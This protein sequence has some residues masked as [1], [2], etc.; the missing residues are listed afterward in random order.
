MAVADH[1]GRD[2][3]AI[4][5]LQN[6]GQALGL[7]GAADRTIDFFDGHGSRQFD[8]QIHH[9]AIGYRHPRG[10]AVQAALKFRQYHTHRLGGAGGGG[11]DVLRRGA[12]APPVRMGDIGEALVIGI[13][14]HR[15]DH[16]F[17]NTEGLVQHPRHG[18]QAIGGAARVR[19]NAVRRI[20]TGLVHAQHHRVIDLVLRRHG[21]H[22]PRCAGIEMHLELLALAKHP[23]RLHHG[24]DAQFGPGQPGRIAFTEQSRPAVRRHEVGVF[25]GEIVRKGAHHRVVVEQITQGLVIEEIVDRDDFHIVALFH[26]AIHRAADAAKAIDGNL[27]LSH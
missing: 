22:D 12:T 26:D 14:M 1:V 20:E 13:G 7:C 8:K 5:V 18:R 21:E 19:D 15:V 17:V 4:A 16:A 9:R 10:D 2:Q 3:R 27:E 6:A 11:N 23:G 25:Q 24:V